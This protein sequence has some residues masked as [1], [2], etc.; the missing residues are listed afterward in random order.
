MIS[1]A[2]YFREPIFISNGSVIAGYVL[3]EQ[4]LFFFKL[5]VLKKNFKTKH[6]MPICFCLLLRKINLFFLCI[7]LLTRPSNSLSP[8]VEN[9]KIHVHS[10]DHRQVLTDFQ[11]GLWLTAPELFLTADHVTNGSFSDFW[12]VKKRIISS[13]LI[14]G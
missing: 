13:Q 10:S 4:P 14:V 7:G 2:L 1:S 8:F 12:L 6:L 3:L 11:L 9:N 5:S